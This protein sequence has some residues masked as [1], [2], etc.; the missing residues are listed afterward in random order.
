LISLSPL[1]SAH[2]S[3]FQPTLVRAFNRCYP[4]FTLAKD[5]SLSFASIPHD[6]T[7]YS[8][9]LSLWLRV[10]PLNLLHTVTRRVV[11]QKARRHPL[12]RDLA[13]TVCRHT[14]SGAISLPFRGTFHHSL[15]VLVHYR[16]SD[17]FSLAG[18]PPRVPSGFHVSERTQVPAGRNHVF[19]YGAVTLCGT[20][21]S[22]FR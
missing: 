6:S 10:L 16:S 9:S 1:S 19:A 11:I 12:S 4:A 18:W 5:R 8:D 17:V 22:G 7:P 20:L 3:R 14:V 2:P 15:T 13:P 21:S